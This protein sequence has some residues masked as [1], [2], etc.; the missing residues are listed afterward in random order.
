MSDDG[1]PSGPV[2]APVTSADYR[3]L[4]RRRLP[5][6][7]FDY[8]DGAAN[9]ETTM[10]RNEADFRSILLRQKVMVDVSGVSTKTSLA[11]EAVAMPLALAPVGLAGM[12]ARRGEVLAARAAQKAGVP[13][14]LSTVG[15][16][17]V[18]EVSRAAPA[19]W[20]QLYMM[21]DRGA[22]KALLERAQAAGVSRLVFTV[23]LAVTGMRHRDVR[24][25]LILPGF[26]A[27]LAKFRQI[28]ARPRWIA[29]VAVR[30]APLGFG[31]LA[32]IGPEAGDLG[33]IRKWVDA[34][35]DPSV[36]WKDI[37]W[38]RGVWKGALILKGVM[39]ADDARLA[40]EAGADAIIVSNHGGRQLD[41]VA[42]SISKLPGAVEAAQGRA[43]VLVD[44]G[45]RGGLDIFRALALGARGVL[46][47]RPWVYAL[48]GAGEQ[49][50]V[51]LLSTFR[52]ELAVAM[53]LAG[54]TRVE[55]IS[56]AALDSA[57]PK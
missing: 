10:A 34:Q 48:A 25:G 26:R 23:D 16:C 1:K 18:D 27:K 15:V 21:R 24:D 50:L 51:D 7:L 45:V 37:E 3:R 47:G 22:V 31:N 56:R 8:L 44:G 28:A 36:T 54:V 43:E 32:G 39:E 9:D 5:Q 55:D 19:P 53:A 40:V 11:G 49:A 17:S 12:F 30:G 41:G 38:L 33:A 13:F 57:F 14:A 4:A 20:F 52:R 35:F 46:I 2:F 6:F 29:D 42:S